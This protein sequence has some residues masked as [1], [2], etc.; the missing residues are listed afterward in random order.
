[1][2]LPIAFFRLQSFYSQDSVIIKLGRGGGEKGLS[3]E[4]FWEFGVRRERVL[5]V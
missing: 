2:S 4:S 5:N 3:L 1:M